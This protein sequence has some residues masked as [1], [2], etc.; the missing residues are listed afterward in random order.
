[1]HPLLGIEDYVVDGGEDGGIRTAVF[2]EFG[3]GIASCELPEFERWFIL[4]QN[5][6]QSVILLSVYSKGNTLLVDL[7]GELR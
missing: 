4:S 7:S 6:F 2:F 5:K 3:E 1:M